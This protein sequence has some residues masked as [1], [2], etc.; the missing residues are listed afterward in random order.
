MPPRRRLE[1]EEILGDL[2]EV[3]AE[4]SADESSQILLDLLRSS[5]KLMRDRPHRGDLKML[6]QAL[7]ELRYAFRVFAPYRSVRKVSI[8][9]SARTPRSAPE[10]EEAMR[11][12]NLI[13]ARGWMVITG[14]GPGIMEAAQGGAGRA[15]SFGVNIRL[16]FEQKANHVIDRDP[17]LVNFKYFFTRKLIFVKETSAIALFPGGFGTHDESF[18][19]LTLVQTGKCQPLPIVFIDRP[20]GTYWKDWQGYIQEHLC[21]RGL[22]D[23]D[24]MGLF[25]V[26]DDP[27][28]AVE[29]ITAF[30]RNYHSSRFVRGR[31][32]LRLLEPVTA[33]LLDRLNTSFSD[34]LTSGR[35]EATGPLPEEKDEPH[36]LHL[37]RL[38][39]YFDLRSFGRLR[40]LIDELNRAT[41]PV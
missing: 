10:F 5:V 29:A 4:R 26:I 18:E 21:D 7:K 16:P 28:R 40:R 41:A 8:F 36:T 14:A 34:V 38:A 19:S 30:Y 3:L 12:A 39:M 9:G 31:M 25:D 37:P 2:R 22:I 11:F 35:I 1:A 24:D 32:V 15:L 23:P 33:D 6:N 27:D 20:G 13:A 17:K